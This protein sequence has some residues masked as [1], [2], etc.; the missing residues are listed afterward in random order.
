MLVVAAGQIRPFELLLPLGSEG[1]QPDAEQ[2][3]HL[4]RRHRIAGVQTVDPGR[5]G[6]DPH[7]RCFAA[8]G[9]IA[10]ECDMTFLCRIQGCDL[11]GQVV[12]PRAR[13]QL[14]TAHRHASQKPASPHQRS[15]SAAVYPE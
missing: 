2:R 14:V 12:V 13:R 9:V 5:P 6:A 11:P 1:M 3:L 7:T 15:L 8:L 10:G 4:L